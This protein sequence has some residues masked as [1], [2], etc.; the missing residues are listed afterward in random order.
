MPSEIKTTFE[1]ITSKLPVDPR[2]LFNLLD[3]L[4]ERQ[5]VQGE[6][7]D[8]FT[9]KKV[10]ETVKN[11]KVLTLNIMNEAQKVVDLENRH[12]DFDKV[13]NVK[14]LL[15]AIGLINIPTLKH[16]LFAKGL[17]DI[18]EQMYVYDKGRWNFYKVLSITTAVAAKTIES[19]VSIDKTE[20]NRNIDFYSLGL[21][22]NIGRLCMNAKYKDYHSK[23]ERKINFELPVCNRKKIEK[24]VYSR[25]NHLILGK[26]IA[27]FWGMPKVYANA[28]YYQS[29]I[30]D[31][32]SHN[33]VI[34]IIVLANLVAKIAMPMHNVLDGVYRDF[35]IRR[36][37]FLEKLYNYFR[38]FKD[39]NEFDDERLKIII[40][41]LVSSVNR[42]SSAI[43]T[44]MNIEP[45]GLEPEL[46]FINL[47]EEVKGICQM[48]TNSEKG[49]A[50]IKDYDPN[51][52]IHLPGE[53]AEIYVKF[54]HYSKNNNSYL[55]YREFCKYYTLLLTNLIIVEHLKR[56][57]KK[58]TLYNRLLA[59]KLKNAILINTFFPDLIEYGNDEPYFCFNHQVFN[60]AYEDFKKI[61][62]IPTDKKNLK[63][64]DL[65]KPLLS[66]VNNYFFLK[67]SYFFTILKVDVEPP[68]LVYEIDKWNVY[69][70]GDP[71][72]NEKIKTDA[73][74]MLDTEG[75]KV[76]LNILE[77]EIY[78][79]SPWI[80]NL[81]CQFCGT[82]HI[83]LLKYIY[84]EDNV[85]YANYIMNN[86][87]S[88]Y[89]CSINIK[90]DD[91]PIFEEIL[92]ELKNFSKNIE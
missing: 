42:E 76:Y 73:K 61:E 38:T 74:N 85:T 1:N 68:N 24:E 26:E 22:S 64:T 56:L 31:L 10:S 12:R 9:F 80:Y 88:D 92:S 79:V 39:F 91:F 41:N 48:L 45:A 29:D 90:C 16:I 72:S 7:V 81:D 65:I 14:N 86:I 53:L 75:S 25:D 20:E 52:C 87:K 77:N 71:A 13:K 11:C 49:A 63:S 30:K 46:D 55:H 35:S 8:H 2:I 19:H 4:K 6:K 33:K 34:K 36:E 28:A 3:L 50:L 5:N 17:E 47:M 67:T 54:F 66:M 59:S 83:F 21:F 40:F 27:K 82:K 62:S 37:G 70:S 89:E 51:L 60:E 78:D 32:D 18:M 43:L 44:E 57:R 58:S 15:H 84:T 23:V 69:N